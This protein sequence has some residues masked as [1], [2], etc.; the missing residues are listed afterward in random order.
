MLF[1]SREI[2]ICNQPLWFLAEQCHE[3]A[4]AVIKGFLEL[5]N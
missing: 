5:F 2:K 4:T 1:M 3:N